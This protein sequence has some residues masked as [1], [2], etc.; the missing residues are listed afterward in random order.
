MRIQPVVEGH[1]EVRA[2][3]VL[4]RRL[5]D[6]SGVHDLEFSRPIRRKRS[7]LVNEEPLRRTIRLALLREEC[8]GILILF[9]ADDDPPCELGPRVQ[10]WASAEAAAVPCAVVMAMREYEAW[11]LVW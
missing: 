6:A 3:P 11:L 1:G 8:A 9:D 4:L 2:L 10:S 7:E 5:S